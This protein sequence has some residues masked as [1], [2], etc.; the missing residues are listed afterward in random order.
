MTQVFGGK[1]FEALFK[2]AAGLDVDKSDIKRLYELVNQKMHDFLQMGEV[3]AK[4]NDRDIIQLY[5]LPITKGF[6]EHL[7]EVRSYDENLN[8]EPILQQLAT[9]PPLKLEYSREVEDA[10]PEL[11]GAI[12]VA[13][14][15]S[16]KAVNPE[17]KNPKP[18]DW[19]RVIDIFNLL[20]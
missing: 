14:A 11:T 20:F 15:K 6:Q 9:L 3:A 1:K 8:L 18:Q 5:D 2:N 4:A 13:L 16:F 19:E 10:L 12:T 7:R 17:L